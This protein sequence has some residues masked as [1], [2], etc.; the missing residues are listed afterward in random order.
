MG[1]LFATRNQPRRIG[2]VNR[3]CG[4]PGVQAHL[5]TA[6][7]AERGCIEYGESLVPGAEP[8]RVVKLL[9]MIWK[10]Y[11]L[12]SP[13]RIAYFGLWGN[14]MLIHWA[15]SVIEVFD[16]YDDHR[17]FKPNVTHA[18]TPETPG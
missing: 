17:E 1:D 7:W 16:E 8:M 3:E 6:A 11:R 18:D 14:G 2:N 12:I 4:T 15:E 13:A 10:N 9:Q 5:D